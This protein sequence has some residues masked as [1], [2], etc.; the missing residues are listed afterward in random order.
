MSI[1]L[2]SEIFPPK[3][4]GSGRWFFELY[5]R[6]SPGSVTI[7]TH[8]NQDP[9][10]Q[11][12]DQAY[13]QPTIRQPM[14]SKSWGL[15]SIT[16]LRFYGRM[17]Y[18]ALKQKPANLS[19]IHCGRTIHE[20]FTGLMLS[21]LLRKPLICYVHGED[22]EVARS[23]RELAFMVRQV[24]KGS[25]KLIC[26][27]N[28]TKNLLVEH[29]QIP[30]DKITV[31]HPGVDEQRFIPVPADD[32]FREQQGWQQRI[33]CLTVGRLQKRKGHDRMIMALPQ[34]VTQYQQFLYVIV[35]N[36][37]ELPTLKQLVQQYQ[38][39]PYVQFKA[40]I[41]D[42]ELI[43]CY[44]QCDFFILPNRTEGNDI[45]GFGMVLVEAQAAGKP[46]IAGDSG[47]TRETM[48]VGTTGLIA[49]CTNP[50]CI[51][52]AVITLLS[53]RS[54]Q[55]FSAEQCRTHVI[56]HYTWQQHSVKAKAIFK[57]FSKV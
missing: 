8:D 47:G 51:Q 17:L 54:E 52:N 28:N 13:P 6:L 9:E 2:L 27:S 29:W 14:T 12:I 15:K 34:I 32:T 21:K 10:Q 57:S 53:S 26:N 49:D 1:L 46:V 4:G 31:L 44:Q 5:R 18:Q 56:K 50:Q 38:V 7:L 22:V 20:G 3:H 35:G 39:E 19:Q 30:V 42:A 23:S 41:T 33:V 37:E 11:Q 36:G 16:G 25:T 55:Q 48:L 45:E 43:Q 40:E 24:L